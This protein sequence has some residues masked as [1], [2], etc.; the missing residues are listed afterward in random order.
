MSR[1]YERYGTRITAQASAAITA[2][3][4]STGSVTLI[5]K[6]SGQNADGA[7]WFDVYIDVTAAPAGAATCELWISGSSDGTDESAYEYALSVAVPVTA[8]DQYRLGVLYGTPQE[9][10]AKIKAISNGFTAALYLTPAWI[11][12]A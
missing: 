7:Q 2:N 11:A 4:L 8:T 6:A 3:L 10:Y 9:F 1:A 5:D 12:D